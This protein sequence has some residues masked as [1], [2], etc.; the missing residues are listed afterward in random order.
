MSQREL[1]IIVLVIGIIF[2]YQ[3]KNNNANTSMN[4]YNW[5]AARGA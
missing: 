2:I 1:L 3:E 5:K 4:Q